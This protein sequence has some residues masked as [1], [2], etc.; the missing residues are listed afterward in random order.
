[1]SELPTERVC[2]GHPFCFTGVD[3]FGPLFVKQ[4]KSHVKR[5]GC[6]FYVFNCYRAVHIEIACSLTTDSFIDAWRFIG[7][8]GKPRTIFSGNGSNFVGAQSELWWMY[9]YFVLVTI[10]VRGRHFT[11]GGRKKFALKIAICPETNFV[12]LIRMGPETL[13]KSVLYSWIRL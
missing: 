9:D 13:C 12:V 2:D 11:G 10:G 1:M 4:G 8:R 5:Y 7:R 3:Y 6:L